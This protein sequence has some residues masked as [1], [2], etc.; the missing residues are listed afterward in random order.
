[1]I[2]FGVDIN[3]IIYTSLVG[4]VVRLNRKTVED[5]MYKYIKTISYN[6]KH[7]IDNNIIEL[8]GIHKE[9]SRLYKN[10]YV[11]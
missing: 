7:Q 6:D 9:C 11:Y 3:Y 2:E 1:M 10:I 8:I 5:N 4:W